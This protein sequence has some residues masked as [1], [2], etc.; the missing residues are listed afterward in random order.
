M[1]VPK[2]RTSSSKRDMRRSHHALRA[3]GMSICPNCQEVRAPHVACK[4]CGHYRGRQVIP[5][6]ESNTQEWDG[7]GGFKPD[8]SN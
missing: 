1:P 5:A 6:Q 7:S 2:F 3:A 4:A 8:A